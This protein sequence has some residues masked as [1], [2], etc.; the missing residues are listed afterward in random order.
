MTESWI[1]YQKTY[2]M[3]HIGSRSGNPFKSIGH[4]SHILK[5]LRSFFELNF[6]CITDYNLE[7]VLFLAIF[8][9][10]SVH[11]TF[12][13]Y[14]VARAEINVSFAF[15]THTKFLQDS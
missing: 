5:L 10:M 15:E 2:S 9:S 7:H 11:I 14:C 4:L 3:S 13:Q 1:G 12:V 8:A 6:A